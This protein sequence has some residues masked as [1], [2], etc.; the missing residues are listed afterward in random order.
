[1]DKQSMK[2]AK[3]LC[4]T[5]L[6]PIILRVLSGELVNLEALVLIVSL[7]LILSFA[8]DYNGGGQSPA[9]SRAGSEHY[10][11]RPTTPRG[12]NWVKHE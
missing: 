2:V 9:F 3:L 11:N 4:S 1:M 6:L 12:D 10:P 8:D 5:I 7:F